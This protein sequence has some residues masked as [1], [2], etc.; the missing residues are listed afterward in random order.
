MPLLAFLVLAAVLPW[1]RQ[2]DR[3]TLKLED[4]HAE[5][6][7]VNPSTFRFARQWGTGPS[8]NRPGASAPVDVAQS[9]T[10]PAVEFRS[11][12]LVVSVRKSDLRL[13]ITDG[14]GK[15]LMA[16]SAGVRHE[17]GAI[18][19]ETALSRDEHIY[20]L[21]AETPGPLDRR[22]STL[23]ATRGFLWSTAG[24]GRY[25]PLPDRYDFD[26]T[27]DHCRVG[28]RGAARVEHY[29]YYGPMPKEIMEQHVQVAPQVTTWSPADLDVLRANRLPEYAAPLPGAAA[30][31]GA[32][33][34]TVAR[35]NHLSLSA[36][37]MPAFDLG[38]FASAPEALR[39]RA[40]QLAM[41]A[42]L[43]AG[44]RGVSEAVT[45][46]RLR[47]RPYLF[48]YF[49]EAHD[50]GIPLIRPLLVQFPGDPE[51]P[52]HS[53]TFMLGDEMLAAP[54]LTPE[55]GRDLYLP[56]G[57][58]TDLRT[59]QT[60]PGRRTVHVE[61]TPGEPPLFAKNGAI[62]PFLED[63]NSD[64][65]AA[66]Y[67]PKLGGEFF[68]FEPDV[69]D[70]TQL[71]ASPAGDYYR[72]EIESKVDREYEWVAHHLPAPGQVARGDRVFPRA[73]S[74]EKLRAGTWFHDRTAGNL[75]IRVRAAAGE[76]V[77]VNVSF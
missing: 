56:M 64:R 49:Q 7:W 40:A 30:G 34:D 2:G 75:H 4:G 22:G 38:A 51:T 12:Y 54:V 26:L 57:I 59:N 36:V 19:L 68:I 43:V 17:D 42:P 41:V 20:G 65:V 24:Y 48:A 23:S 37:Q 28:A 31:W 71:H 66:H 47:L 39:Q 46:W 15:L 32:L 60:Y 77:I 11:T 5:L 18:V 8:R 33:A 72:F 29:F 62:V 70:H 53:D 1:D 61:A 73:E 74:K 13:R 69:S 45:R 21:G 67:F 44:G 52:K 6:D 27:G 63:P 10:G 25:F 50:R 16:E 55:N 35:W 58:W 76:D 3:F 9:D 14:R